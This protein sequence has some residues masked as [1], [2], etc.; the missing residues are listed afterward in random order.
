M[1][2]DKKVASR[3]S[4]GANGRQAQGSENEFHSGLIMMSVTGDE[5]DTCKNHCA[6]CEQLRIHWLS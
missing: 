2:L 3:R 6:P 5:S 1:W 4:F